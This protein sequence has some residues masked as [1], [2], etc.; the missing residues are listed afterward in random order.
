MAPERGSRSNTVVH[1]Q[2]P[3]SQTQLYPARHLA[4]AQDRLGY[5]ERLT[6]EGSCGR[7]PAQ[8]PGVREP[9]APEDLATRTSPVHQHPHALDVRGP[10][11]RRLRADAGKMVQAYATLRSCGSRVTHAVGGELHWVGVHQQRRALPSPAG[12]APASAPP[13]P[14]GRG[15]RASSRRIPA[16]RCALPPPAAG[17]PRRARRPPRRR[18]CHLPRASTRRRSAG[19]GT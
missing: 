1:R 4:V 7:A 8:A 13:P 10:H 16:A 6:V 18:R 19:T 5:Q 12:P 9:R 2:R 11:L 17:P 14:A 15:W 3:I